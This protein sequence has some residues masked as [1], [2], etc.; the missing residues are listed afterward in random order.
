MNQMELASSASA[1]RSFVE[2]A[3]IDHLLLKFDVYKAFFGL[4][5]I[6]P[7]DVPDQTACRLG[8]WYHQG[9]GHACYSKLPGYRELDTPHGA[10]HRAAREA[11]EALRGGDP[12][13]GAEAIGRMETAS[14]GVIDGL[15]RIAREGE[16][17]PG[18][19]NP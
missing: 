6:G 15:E 18:L 19:L 5:R 3:K 7:N 9:D 8:R 11:L 14:T 12:L 13:R 4:G 10:M 2:A 16:S 1:L 17:N